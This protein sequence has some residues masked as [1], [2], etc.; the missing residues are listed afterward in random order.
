[1]DID[2]FDFDLFKRRILSF[3]TAMRVDDEGTR[4]RYSRSCGQATLYASAYACMTLSLLGELENLSEAQRLSWISYF[5]GFQ[6]REDGLFYDPV[7]DSSLFRSADWWGARHLTLHMINAYTQLGA[8]PK[9]PFNFLRAYYN[10]SFIA[11]WIR[12]IDWSV[13]VP[14]ANDVDNQIMNIGCLLQYQRDAW[15]DGDAAKAVEFLQELLAE[16]VSQATGMW[17]GYDSANRNQRSRMVQFA[18]HLFVFLLYDGV[19]VESVGKIISNALSTQ[20]SLGGFGVKLN[21][22]ACEDIDSIDLLIR[23]APLASDA[24]QA[25][26]N[27]LRRAWKWV[28]A[29]QLDDGGFVFRLFESF[30]YGHRETSAG[31]NEGAMLPTWFRTLSLAYLAHYFKRRYDFQIISNPGYEFLTKF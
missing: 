17:G 11:S 6:S 19:R 26:D 13:A 24:R 18:Y 9:Y 15:G 29:N 23:F 10:K 3:I 8:M 21:S 31:A 27:A 22:S 28:L 1:M 30:S 20:N 5:D 4:Y 12:A 16:H 2:S 14:S 25:V 7:V